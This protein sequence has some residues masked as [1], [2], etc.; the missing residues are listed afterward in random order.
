MPTVA[1]ATPPGQRVDDPAGPPGRADP[2]RR[3]LAGIE[4]EGRIDR[5]GRHRRAGP[6]AAPLTQVGGL[7]ARGTAAARPMMSAS[8]GQMK[9]APPTSAPGSAAQA[10]GA[11]D[12]ELCRRRPGKQVRGRDGILELGLAQPALALDGRDAR[13]MAMWVG[14][15]PNPV[16]PMRPHCAAIVPRE[17]SGRASGA[18]SVGEG[19]SGSSGMPHV[20]MPTLGSG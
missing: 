14:G 2:A 18:G 3:Q 16:Q 9:Q 1:A 13:S 11:E 20:G 7:R 17:T 15:P 5:H 12:G 19:S 4:P 8:P 6:S 10:P